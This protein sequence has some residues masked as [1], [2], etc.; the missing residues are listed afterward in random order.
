MAN[1]FPLIIKFLFLKIL[2]FLSPWHILLNTLDN[3]TWFKYEIFLK[4]RNLTFFY[5]QE[6]LSLTFFTFLSIFFYRFVSLFMY[7]VFHFTTNRIIMFCKY[8]IPLHYRQDLL[9]SLAIFLMQLFLSFS[10]FQIFH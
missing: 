1:Q 6:S 10:L 9:L 5:F 3:V 8:I 4:F 7:I 2:N